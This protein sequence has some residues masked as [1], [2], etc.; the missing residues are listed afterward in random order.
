ML[1]D[2]TVL[3]DTLFILKVLAMR[4]SRRFK[5]SKSRSA[6]TFRKNVS[7]VAGANVMRGGWR[8]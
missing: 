7:R 2:V 8:L 3:G 4:P 5:V 1:L 6:R